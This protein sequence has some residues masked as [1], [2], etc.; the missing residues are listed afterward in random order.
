MKLLRLGNPEI[1]EEVHRSSPLELTVAE[2]WQGVVCSLQPSLSAQEMDLL[3]DTMDQAHWIP[4]VFQ[5]L[6][7]PAVICK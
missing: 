5:N 3:F 4:L 1:T 6:G 2:R 7:V